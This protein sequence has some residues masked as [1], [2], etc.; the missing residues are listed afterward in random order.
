[1]ELIVSAAIIMYELG[2]RWAVESHTTQVHSMQQQA[3]CYIATI[4]AL[5]LVN[6]TYQWIPTVQQQQQMGYVAAP[7]SP[8]RK[9]GEDD[10][11][12]EEGRSII[13]MGKP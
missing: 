8:K 4:N 6:P 2:Q 1:M 10:E 5:R 7:P 11:E 12:D 3:N 9:R 13:F